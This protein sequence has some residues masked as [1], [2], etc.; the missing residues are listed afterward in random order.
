MF[1]ALAGLTAPEA[2]LLAAGAG[3]IGQQMTNSAQSDAANAQ[4]NFQADMSN[5]AYQRQVKDLEAAG[6]NPML[7]YMKGGGASTP[8]GAMPTY[9]S[10]VSAGTNAALGA[11]QA[12]REGATIPKIGAETHLLGV[13]AEQT[14]ANTALINQT[15]S[16]LKAE[17]GLI[18]A[19]TTESE[20]RGENL[21]LER[22]RIKAVI[23]EL[24]AQRDLL[25]AK[26]NS[27]AVQTNVLRQTEHE[28]RNNN[29]IGDAFVDASRKTGFIGELAKSVKPASEIAS[30]WVDKLLPWKTKTS[31]T[32]TDVIRD[33][34]G[35]EVRRFS[36]TR[37][38]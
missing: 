10:A 14:Q 12:M 20:L 5:T 8:A 17:I 23:D 22:D 15:V 35:R 32:H 33:S 7:A 31:E 34:H 16:K 25:R 1:E 21:V 29:I 9:Q 6:L 11:A 13:T 3:F 27:E 18:G 2:T 38:K 28:L 4:M 30:S 19:Q 26:G 24:V 37:S 36:Y